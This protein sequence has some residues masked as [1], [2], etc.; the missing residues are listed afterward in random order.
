[1]TL[2]ITIILIIIA[3]FIGF[4]TGRFGDRYGGHINGPHHWILGVILVVLGIIFF[5]TTLGILAFGF[6]IGHFI[7]DLEDF[8]HMR[9]WSVDVPH[10]WKFWSIK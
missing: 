7:S 9:I 10:E 4:A 5:D 3:G 8:L 6:G 1:M 2:L